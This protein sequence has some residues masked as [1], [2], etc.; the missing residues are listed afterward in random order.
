MNASD[1]LFAAANRLEL[2]GWNQG[3]YLPNVGSLFH[4]HIDDVGAT[5]LTG[6]IRLV[7]GG[8]SNHDSDDAKAEAK[9]AVRDAIGGGSLGLWND[10]DDRT[11][12]EVIGILRLAAERCKTQRFPIVHVEGRRG[13]VHPGPSGGK[14][15]LV[16]EGT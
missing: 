11:K 1:I 2:K 10:A 13:P 14:M 15:R 9:E 6:A 7:D 5:D 16:S 12:E 4:T 8:Y 3:A